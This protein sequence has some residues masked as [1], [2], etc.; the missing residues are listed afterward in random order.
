MLVRDIMTTPV[1]TVTPATPV[2]AAAP[3]LSGRGF[4]AL[5]VVDD[6]GGLV[7]IVTEA[8]L[9]RDRI[10]HD[11]RSPLLSRELD[12]DGP[13]SRVSDVMTVDVV[14]ARTWTDVADLVEEMQDRGIR[15]VPVVDAG[16]VVGI[17]SRRDVVG[18]LTR[19]DAAIA[20]DVRRRLESYAGPGRWTVSVA[21]GVVTLADPFGD[22]AEQHTA[23]VL[24]AAVR[25]VGD[26]R[27]V[28]ASPP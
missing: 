6:A 4:T 1:L 22:P 18:T 21:G 16:T 15:S 13:P 10:R 11:P 19:A 2:R 26:V 20:S 9:L 27:V 25:G 12:A 3:L 7:G 24:A 14:T 8:D 17:V 23:A 5:P 28:P